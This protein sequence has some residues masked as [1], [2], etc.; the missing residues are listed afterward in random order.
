MWGIL[1]V[2]LLALLKTAVDS[3]LMYLV[4]EQGLECSPFVG[5]F[6]GIWEAFSDFTV[7]LVYQLMLMGIIKQFAMM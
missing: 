6:M 4:V 7:P 3:I 2:D 1:I 5:F